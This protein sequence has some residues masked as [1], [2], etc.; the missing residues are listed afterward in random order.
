M[1]ADTPIDPATFADLKEAAGAEFV[2]DLVGTF[3]DEAPRMLDDMRT[4]LAAGNV[5][6]FRRAAHSFK[7]NSNTFG[8]L[9]LGALAR[10]LELSGL[11]PALNAQSLEALRLEYARVATALTELRH[12]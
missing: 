9:V 10:D 7:S 4:A 11:D 3:L 6:A 8:A 1:A 2:A 5:D 12:A